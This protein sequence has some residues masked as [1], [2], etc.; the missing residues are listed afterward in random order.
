MSENLKISVVTV[1]YNAAAT[2]EE[3][4]K[5]VVN[6]SYD[7]IE[8]IIIDGGSTDGTVDIIKRYAPGGSEYGKHP[9]TV[10][11]WISEPDKGI[12]DAMNKGIV[13]ATGDYI[14]FMNAGDRFASD[15]TLNETTK[16]MTDEMPGVYF[17]DVI[18]EKKGQLYTSPMT[19]FF[20]SEK[21]IKPM[22]ICHQSIFTRTDLAKYKKFDTSFKMSADYQ[23]IMSIYNDGESFKQLM[24]PI[25]I[26]DMDGV[27][28]LNWELRM[29]DEARING[30]DKN[31][32]TVKKAILNIKFRK[33]IKSILGIKR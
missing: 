10:S 5:S 6:Q 14:N 11:Y 23:M 8:Y 28:A 22:G 20:L 25:A 13:A 9:N 31:S 24:L 21:K 29:I 19:P 32:F 16:A 3:T 12:Y 7:N 15:Q 18:W 26:Y 30:Y 4:I 27:S 1:S 2:I 17:G 33:F